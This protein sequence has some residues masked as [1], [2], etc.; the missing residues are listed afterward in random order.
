MTCGSLSIPIPYMDGNR[1]APIKSE[2]VVFEMAGNCE[3]TFV[4]I[5]LFIIPLAYNFA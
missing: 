2:G 3:P 4:S 5:Q 1:R